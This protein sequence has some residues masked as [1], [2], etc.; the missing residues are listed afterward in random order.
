MEIFKCPYCKGELQSEESCIICTDCAERF[1]AEEGIYDFISSKID[2][3]KVIVVDYFDE[4][5]P[6]YETNSY[7]KFLYN[8]YGGFEIDEEDVARFNQELQESIDKLLE[9]SVNLVLDV[10]CGTGMFSR[11]LARKAK[12]VFGIDISAGSLK[13]AQHNKFNEKI[14]NL[15]FAR[16]DVENL[17]FKNETFDSISCI[18]ALQL[19]PDTEKALTEMNRVL[20][21]GGRL[22]VMTYLRRRYMAIRFL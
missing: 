10:G 3:D 16:A 15:T 6:F 2:S 19:F 17:P 14:K 5:A 8:F 18:G 11:N 9:S 7:G 12:W 22:V 21:K 20:K 13:K 1:E 4:V